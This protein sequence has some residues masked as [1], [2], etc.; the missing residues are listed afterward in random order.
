[1]VSVKQ[2]YLYKGA[3]IMNKSQIINK[4]ISV[5][6]YYAEKYKLEVSEPTYDKAFKNSIWEGL[7]EDDSGIP[8]IIADNENMVVE[9]RSFW[10]RPELSVSYNSGLLVL[11]Y[12]E[13]SQTH[14]YEV[15]EFRVVGFDYLRKIEELESII[16]FIENEE[17][18]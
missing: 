8:N 9:L 2:T 16:K 15:C 12:K 17:S 18:L 5:I 14:Q 4:M 1:M 11:Q 13:N 10:G 3:I 7:I 6:K